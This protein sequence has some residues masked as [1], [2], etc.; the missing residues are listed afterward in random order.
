MKKIIFILFSLLL[1]MHVF[2]FET[3]GKP[4]L[5]ENVKNFFS[6]DIS[7]VAQQMVG[8]QVYVVY[9]YYNFFS[10]KDKTFSLEIPDTIWIKKRPKK[11]PVYGK[12]YLLSYVYKGEESKLDKYPETD[13]PMIVPSSFKESITIEKVEGKK[14]FFTSEDGRK[15]IW[16][17]G[18]R[19]RDL[20][21]TS[22]EIN[23]FLE[24]NLKDYTIYYVGTKTSDLVLKSKV[25]RLNFKL[26]VEYGSGKPLQN[27]SYI[28]FDNGKRHF[29]ANGQK[30]EAF[31]IT[32]T[33][34]LAHAAAKEDKARMESQKD[35]VFNLCVVM[36]GM[37]WPD[38]N[39]GNEINFRNSK[40]FVYNTKSVAGAYYKI[41]FAYHGKTYEMMEPTLWDSKHL[42]STQLAKLAFLKKRYGKGVDVRRETALALDKKEWDRQKKAAQAANHLKAEQRAK[43]VEQLKKDD[44]F[45]V[46]VREAESTTRATGIT[47][48]VFNCFNKPIKYVYFSA[49]AVNSV[50]DVQSDHFG[51]SI[52]NDNRPGI[53]KTGETRV[54]YNNEMFWDSGYK[55][56]DVRLIAIKFVFTDGTEK[57]YTSWTN[58]KPHYRPT[59]L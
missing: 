12:H 28:A 35:S 49:C 48:T 8:H 54:V 26:S 22:V 34:A 31:Y 27:S 24:D 50:G 53:I 23:N 25:D 51:R 58:I 42:D 9:N 40:I 19:P 18:E 10:N 46:E 16:D 59:N 14:M 52:V 47:F 2:A 21:V 13:I 55:I 7:E 15:V 29:Y 44:I 39:N 57:S 43:V 17:L 33:A 20:V 5:P 11:H 30:S 41:E 36:N 45:L 3:F 38:N 4:E 56:S 37:Y 6:S 32:Q 1:Q